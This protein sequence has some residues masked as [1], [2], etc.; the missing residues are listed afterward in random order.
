MPFVQITILRQS[1]E[2]KAELSKVITDEINRITGIPK[3]VISI[4]YYELPAESFAT[5]GVMLSEKFKQE[6]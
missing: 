1:A 4:G 3:E 2:K 6:H 5:N